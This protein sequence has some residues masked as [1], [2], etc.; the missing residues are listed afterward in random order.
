MGRK[1]RKMRYCLLIAACFCAAT[2]NAEPVV[3]WPINNWRISEYY[4][5]ESSLPSINPNFVYG[6]KY[7]SAKTIT[8]EEMVKYREDLEIYEL[9]QKIERA[10]LGKAYIEDESKRPKLPHSIDNVNNAVAES[11]RHS[12]KMIED[13]ADWDFIKGRRPTGF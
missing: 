11:I 7:S 4:F 10:R 8:Q 6:N 1:V 9:E 2:A 12:T 3:P 13:R 5:K